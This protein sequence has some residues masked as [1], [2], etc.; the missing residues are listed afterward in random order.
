ML[1]ITGSSNE[2]PFPDFKINKQYIDFENLERWRLDDT[3]DLDK[4]CRVTKKKPGVKSLPAVDYICDILNP[5]IPNPNHVNGANP[6]DD[7]NL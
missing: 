5:N 4:Y 3:I 1:H 2:L 7:F 6:D